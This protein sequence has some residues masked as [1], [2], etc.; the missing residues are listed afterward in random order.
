VLRNGEFD[1]ATG[2]AGD[3]VEVV[4]YVAEYLGA[5]GERLRAGERIIAGTLAP[6]VPVAPGD[7][8]LFEAGPLGSLALEFTA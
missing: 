4:R 2:L 3:L 5:F 1:R 8:L 7:R 6:A